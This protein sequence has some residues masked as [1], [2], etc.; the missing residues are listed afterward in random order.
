MFGNIPT[1]FEG[2][3]LNPKPNVEPEVNLSTKRSTLMGLGVQGFRGFR[4]FGVYGLGAS[5]VLRVWGLGV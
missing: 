5:V 3:T 2:E 1:S 4:G